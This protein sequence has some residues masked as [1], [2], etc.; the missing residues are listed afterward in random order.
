MAVFIG[1]SGEIN[2]AEFSKNG[3][4][5]LTASE[6]ATAKLWNLDGS[7]IKTFGETNSVE[8]TSATFS[9]DE[10]Y[11]VVSSINNAIDFWN[12]PKKNGY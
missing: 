2:Q 10:Q 11:A 3:K 6:D 7:L 4:Y 5:I 8:Y 9:R 1:H 12:M